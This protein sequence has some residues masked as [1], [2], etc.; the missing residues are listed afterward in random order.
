MRTIVIGITVLFLAALVEIA[1]AREGKI[2]QE[3]HQTYKLS[4]KGTISLRN[5]NGDVQIKV[6]DKNDV[7]VDAV[8]YASDQEDMDNLKI[9]VDVSAD[10]I[11]ID[12]EYPKHEGDHQGG[13]TAVEYVLTVPK[14]V[15][16]DE[17]KTVNG[18][19]EI[20]GVS[21]EVRA[22]TVNGT[23]KADGLVNTCELKTVNGSVEAGFATVPPEANVR[24]ESVNGALTIHLPDN[25]NANLRAKAQTGNLKSDFDLT[26]KGDGDTH[27]FVRIGTSVKG[28][29][30]KGGAE[31]EMSTVNG[32]IRI[33]KAGGAD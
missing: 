21:G 31:I 2:K 32:S 33:L 24:L 12:T 22:S 7:Q 29:I 25:V 10:M 16:I 1:P 18:G 20:P 8:K 3:F 5:V 27:S 4:A 9:E 28:T 6:W 17:I 23:I 15:N 30:G 11:D 19:I 13:E 26:L 14:D